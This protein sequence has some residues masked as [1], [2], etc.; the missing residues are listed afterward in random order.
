MIEHKYANING[1]RMHFA[2][3]GKGSLIMFL[4]G[5]PEYWGVWKKQFME[6]AKD[7]QVVA[8]DMR[9]Y[10]LTEK[11]EDVKKYHIKFL[12]EDIRELADFLGHKKFL[13][14]AEDWGA[15][16]AW[17]FVLRYPD[18]VDKFVS[19]NATHPALFNK[20]LQTDPNQQK[21][22]QYMLRFRSQEGE[23]WLTSND[24]GFLRQA[25]LAKPLKKGLM[26]QEDAEEWVA[27]WQQ[28]PGS[29]TGGLNYYRA[30]K[31]GPPDEKGSPGGSNLIDDLE[32]E[33][34]RVDV[35]TLL[36]YGE[37][38][39][40]RPPCGFVGLE[41]YISNLTIKK[42]PDASHWITIEKPKLLN[43]YI[44]NFFE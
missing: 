5:F 29:I 15:Q 30:A 35:P 16:V 20:V 18:Y 7:Y 11:P 14:V 41:E 23:E 28:Q 6:F 9:G 34:L 31:E 43:S 37:L 38:D 40:Y 24:F 13:L 21:A 33:D 8:P 36:I 19:I 22:S 12:V 26:M 42:I 27:A 3:E 2:L 1:I 10:N 17:C 4:H 39:I 44:R 25:V 32:P